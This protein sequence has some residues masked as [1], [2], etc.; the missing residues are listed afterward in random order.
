MDLE[1]DHGT[2]AEEQ[3]LEGILFQLPA[4]EKHA[5]RIAEELDETLSKECETHSDI[6][7]VLRSYLNLIVE[8]KG[9]SAM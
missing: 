8:S 5:L 6:D 2:H 1:V 9:T 3:F 7:D 4:P